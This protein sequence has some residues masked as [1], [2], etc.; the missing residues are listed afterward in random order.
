MVDELAILYEEPSFVV[1]NKPTGLLSQSTFGVDSA[2][3]RLRDLL[4][5][6]GSNAA[7]AFVELP[8]RLDRGTSGILLAAKTKGA[9]ASFSEQF[10]ARKTLKRY[11]VAVEGLPKEPSGTLRDWMRKI[12]EVARAEIVRSDEVG[13]REAILDY[14]VLYTRGN[15]CVLMAMPK[16]GRMHQI[17]LQFSSRGM[18]V[19]GDRAYGSQ[20]DWVTPLRSLHEEHFA[21]H[22]G[23]LSFHHPKTGRKLEMTAPLPDVWSAHFPDFQ[24]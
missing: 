8:H 16:T 11:F 23:W 7:P 12:P 1:L 9:L 2:L 24:H 13:S 10:H 19:L 5:S 6:R 14:Q 18:P 4:K 21:L 3:F 20:L 15:V 22:A 17:R